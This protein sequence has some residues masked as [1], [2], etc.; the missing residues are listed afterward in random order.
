MYFDSAQLDGDQVARLVE[1]HGAPLYIYNA[2][3]IEQRIDSLASRA[4]E[5]RFDTVRFAIKA[6]SNIHVLRT[7]RSFGAKVDAVDYEEVQRALAAGFRT[8]LGVD[9][10]Q[11]TAEGFDSAE[12]LAAIARLAVPVN[13]GSVG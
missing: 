2:R 8:G 13:C 11:Y 4:E 6:L 12:S 7:M 10:I 5:P 9:E 1:K 3:V